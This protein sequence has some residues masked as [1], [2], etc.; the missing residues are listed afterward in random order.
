[1]RLT[2]L[3]PSMNVQD[4][5]QQIYPFPFITS[6]VPPE[7]QRLI[8][9]SRDLD[10]QY[11]RG[12]P[13]VPARQDVTHT[14]TLPGSSPVPPELLRSVY[15]NA[16]DARRKRAEA[17]ALSNYGVP[18]PQPQQPLGGGLLGLVPSAGLGSGGLLG[19]LLGRFL[20]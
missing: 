5:R 14:F 7:L 9:A 18:Q 20:R 16:L 12:L 13:P 3:L 19:S 8:N 2:D 17:A 4:Y 11:R 10:A 6:Y 15:L 1:M